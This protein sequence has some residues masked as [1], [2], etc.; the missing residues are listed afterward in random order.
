MGHISMQQNTFFYRRDTEISEKLT[1]FIFSPI[2]LKRIEPGVPISES[3]F[4]SFQN[5]LT[6]NKKKFRISLILRSDKCR[7]EGQLGPPVT[8]P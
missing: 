5:D 7:N 6:R 3:M 8:R 4:Y 1:L 2:A